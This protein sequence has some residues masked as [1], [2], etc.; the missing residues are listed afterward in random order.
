[1]KKT[2]IFFCFLIFRTFGIAQSSSSDTII[3]SKKM[4]SN[5]F[6][7][8][9]GYNYSKMNFLDFGIRYYH[10]RND[11]QQAMA[12]SGL[13]VGSEISLFEKEWN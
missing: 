13:T 4:Y 6:M 8:S 7:T 10:W 11:A 3:S 9:V 12:F 2:F 5:E 1:M